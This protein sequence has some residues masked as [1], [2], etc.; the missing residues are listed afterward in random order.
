MAKAYK[1]MNKDELM[2]ALVDFQTKM[3]EAKEDKK[4]L[5]RD[6]KDM[7]SEISLI[8]SEMKKRV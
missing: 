4:D 5:S 1:D 7:K 6:I 8:T 2:K 3:D